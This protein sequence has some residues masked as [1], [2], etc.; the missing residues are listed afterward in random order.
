MN[1]L[2]NIPIVLGTELKLR[3]HVDP[4]DEYS[5]QDYNFKVEI[6]TNASKVLSFESTDNNIILPDEDRDTCIVLINSKDV[7]AGRVKV[8][9]T[10]DIPDDDFKDGVRTEIA[11]EDTNIMIVRK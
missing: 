4:I 1:V 11:V 10:A 5:L 6:Y 7:G 2:N 8:R 3:I 9:I